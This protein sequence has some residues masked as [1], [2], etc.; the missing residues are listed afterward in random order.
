MEKSFSNNNNEA[1]SS[2]MMDTTN[3]NSQESLDLDS[4]EEHEITHTYIS[5]SRNLLLN[6]EEFSVEKGLIS[7][8]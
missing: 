4:S 7:T 3:S 8:H 2:F 5:I 1:T 6:K